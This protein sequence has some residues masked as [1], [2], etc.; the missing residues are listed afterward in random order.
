MTA[1]DRGRI[2]RWYLP[3][4]AGTLLPLGAGF[5]AS[6]EANRI[7]YAALG[8]A[9]ALAS[10]AALRLLA[11]RRGRAAGVGAHAGGVR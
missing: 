8:L 4:L 6:A 10:I 11:A 5:Y 1:A 3:A 9:A 2:L 7:V